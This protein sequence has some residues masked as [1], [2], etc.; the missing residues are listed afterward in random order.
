MHSFYDT[1]FGELKG[2]VQMHTATLLNSPLVESGVGIC[3]E[4]DGKEGLVELF[5]KR[6][7]IDKPESVCLGNRL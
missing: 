2:C 4:G 7:T 5:M 6:C 1:A 3:D